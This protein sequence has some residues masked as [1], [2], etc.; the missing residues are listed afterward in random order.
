[1][2]CESLEQRIASLEEELESLDQ[3]H[4]S[5]LDVALS[6]RDHL[7]EE[8]RELGLKLT[9]LASEAQYYKVLNF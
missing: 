9:E 4:Q 7:K 6:T 3:Q 2:Q 1:M 5:A 8:N